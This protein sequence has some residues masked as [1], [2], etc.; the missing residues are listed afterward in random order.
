MFQFQFHHQCSLFS[1]NIPSSLSPNLP[2]W[3][4]LFIYFFL[5]GTVVYNTV[6][7]R[8]SYIFFYLIS[9]TSPYM[10]GRKTVRSVTCF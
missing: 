5:L 9:K 8:I 4:P 2:I 3:Q 7:G 1:T 6:T 10:W